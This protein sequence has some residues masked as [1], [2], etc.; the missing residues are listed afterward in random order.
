MTSFT[1]AF[2]V[3]RAQSWQA[4]IWECSPFGQCLPSSKKTSMLL[5]SSWAESR[6]IF[7]LFGPGY[8]FKPRKTA[9][10]ACKWFVTY[11]V[12]AFSVCVN[13]I[14]FSKNTV[15]L[16]WRLLPQTFVYTKTPFH[17]PG[18][19][20]VGHDIVQS[21]PLFGEKFA[22]MVQ[23]ET[24]SSLRPL[25]VLGWWL[26]WWE[27]KNRQTTFRFTQ[28]KTKIYGLIIPE[29]CFQVLALF[30]ANSKG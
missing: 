17:D 10:T 29:D 23:E 2:A 1:K 13:S 12:I 14:V 20:L 27:P 4:G 5:Q 19:L 16:N 11:R 15:Q 28:E 24:K 6:Y 7:I 26:E 9:S 25:A 22:R 21:A 30:K 8:R 18:I 3:L